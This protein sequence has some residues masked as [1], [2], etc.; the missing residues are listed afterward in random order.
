[1]KNSNFNKFT[2][3]F[4]DTHSENTPSNKTEVFK[5]S[6]NMYTWE[7]GISNQLFIRDS[8]AQISFPKKWGSQ[9]EKSI[10]VI[11]L[12]RTPHSTCL[13]IN[14]VVLCGNVPVSF[15][16]LWT[17]K[18]FSSFFF[19]KVLVFKKTCFEVKILKTFKILSA[20]HIKTCRSLKRMPILKIPST[21]FERNIRPFYWL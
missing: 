9:W 13:N 1:M 7:I 19:K 6:M 16:A 17:K 11:G 12:F 18:Q 4:K 10:F 15:V 14:R 20:C 3:W 21:A 8:Y 2:Y 5:K